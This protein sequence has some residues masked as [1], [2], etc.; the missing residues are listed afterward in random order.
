VLA[1]LLGQRWVAESLHTGQAQAHAE[2]KVTEVLQKAR[3]ALQEE[4]A[5]GLLAKERHKLGAEQS[6]QLD[7]LHHRQGPFQ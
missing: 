1:E 3:I 7:D 5:M 4:T 2:V 6:L